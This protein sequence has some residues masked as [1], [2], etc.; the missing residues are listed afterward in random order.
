MKIVSTA[1]V[2]LSLSVTSAFA[3]PLP[4]LPSPNDIIGNTT[5]QQVNYDGDRPPQLD[6]VQI[7]PCDIEKISVDTAVACLAIFGGTGA[8]PAA[9]NVAT[10]APNPQGPPNPRAP[11]EILP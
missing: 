3:A 6:R 4:P 11:S 1:L 8:I 7:Q 5:N 10:R 9:A 2:I